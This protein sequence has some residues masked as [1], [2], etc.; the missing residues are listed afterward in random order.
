MI[1]FY[2]HSIAPVK[3][4]G[5]FSYGATVL[6]KIPIVYPLGKCE[7]QI[8]YFVD[9]ILTAKQSDPQADTSSLEKEI[10]NLVYQ[11]YNLTPDEIE[12]IEQAN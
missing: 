3:Q 11:L 6:E 1:E 8:K 5:Y 2:L 4:G 12:Q 10:D 9:Q 7:E